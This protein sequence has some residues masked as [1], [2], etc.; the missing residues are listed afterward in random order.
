MAVDSGFAGTS[1]LS[2]GLGEGML[3][4]RLRL[5]SSSANTTTLKNTQN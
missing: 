3:L 1:L 4:R 5:F 2:A